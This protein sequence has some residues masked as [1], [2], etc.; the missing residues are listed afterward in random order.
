MGV[1]MRYSFKLSIAFLT[2]FFCI[3]ILA[4]RTNN[5]PLVDQTPYRQKVEANPNQ[6]AMWD[7]ILS[8]DVT[9]LSGA[10]GNAGAEWDGTYFYSTRWASNL[11]HKYNSTGTSLVEEFS[12]PGVSGLRDLAFD[13]TYMY[14]GAAANTIYQ[15]DFNTKTLIGTIW[16]PVAVRFIAYDEVADAFWVGNWS[17]SPTLVSRSGTTLASFST[18]LSGQYGAAYDNIGAGGPFLYIFDQGT[19]AGTPQLIHQFDISSGTATGVVHD[20]NLE[21]P[22]TNGIAGGLFLMTDW[23]TGFPTLGG[24]LQ[25]T[26]DNIFVY[27]IYSCSI[28][29]PYDPV[30]PDAAENISVN[31]SQLSWHF[32]FNSAEVATEP[33]TELYFGMDP[34]NMTLVQS[35]ALDSVWNIDPSYLPLDYY[36]TYYW[37]VLEVV[38][39]CNTWGSLWHFRTE[40]NPVPVALTSFT[41][42]ASD[43]EVNLIWNTAT[44]TNNRGFEIERISLT[45]SPSRGWEKIGF[46]PGFGTTAEPKSYSYIDSKLKAGKYSYRLKQIDFDGTFKFS[47]EVNVDVYTPIQFTLE[48]NYPNPFN[49]STKIKYSVPDVIASGAKQSQLVT[50][51]VYDVLGREVAT[52]VNEEKEAGRFEVVFDART[53]T[54]GIYFYTMEADKF[55]DVKKMIIIK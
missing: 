12:I 23:L 17:D 42:E 15:M 47:E 52:L 19:G 14:G 30:P 53:L 44:E 43:D 54:S 24:T 26:P 31:L 21:F 10:A 39:N 51:K 5:N 6:E 28:P 40:E 22:N 34:N 16:S 25:G 55:I 7:L 11:I 36:T 49:P 38:P 13:G 48:Q 3:S 37:Q 46:V 8:F 20:V 35:G 33:T 4:Q 45:A 18:G 1:F 2:L 41:A 29:P 9:A 32:Y 27:Q 50:I